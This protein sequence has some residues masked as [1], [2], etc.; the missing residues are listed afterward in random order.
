MPAPKGNRHPRHRANG[1]QHSSG[2]HRHQA[3]TA[4][5]RREAKLLAELRALGY[6]ITVPCLVCGHPLTTDRSLALHVGPKCLAKA[7]D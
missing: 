4:D 6:A 2:D 1:Y 5:E 3:P 7:V